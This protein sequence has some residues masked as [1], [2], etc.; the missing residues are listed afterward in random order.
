MFLVNISNIVMA[1]CLAAYNEAT[2]QPYLVQFNLSSTEVGAVFT[3]KS[4][5]QSFGSLFA[6]MLT[7]YKMEQFYIIFGQVLIAIALLIVGPAPFLP[8]HPSLTLIYIGQLLIGLGWS[9]LTVCSITHT[10]RYATNAAGYPNDL[11]TTTFISSSACRCLLLG[12]II[13]PP[14]A[15][16]IVTGYGYR[17]GSM[18][19]LGTLSF[20]M[21]I[22]A[23]S[24]FT[25]ALCASNARFERDSDRQALWRGSSENVGGLQDP[26]LPTILSRTD[27]SVNHAPA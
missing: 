18:F 25:S 13:M 19:M 23:G 22:T 11:K 7:V 24:W 20:F 14:I 8:F 4:C 12:G 10:L 15:T 17:K 26:R 21:L 6:G 1:S 5:G 2:L 3:V 27:S 16:F 9:A